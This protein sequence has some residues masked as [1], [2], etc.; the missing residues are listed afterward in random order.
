MKQ[1]ASDI[2]CH[3]ILPVA[4]GSL[5]YVLWRDDSLL[6]FRWIAALGAT[7]VV[8]SARIMVAPL[9]LS[10]PHV[11]LFSLPDGLWAYGLTAS[12]CVIWRSRTG[13]AKPLWLSC[14]LVL[15]IGSELA[16]AASALPG[17]FELSDLLLYA[18]APVLAC[19][20]V[21]QKGDLRCT[22]DT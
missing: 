8:T 17:V 15:G 22:R 6:V 14:G 13:R 5:I 9:A 3:C 12:M 2:F 18:G 19:L 10:L 1:N 11:V 7:E 4:L 16:Q 20:V 21:L